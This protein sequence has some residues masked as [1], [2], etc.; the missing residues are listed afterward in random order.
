MSLTA[1]RVTTPGEF[2]ALAPAWADLAARSGR[3]S[4]F[5]SHDWFRSCWAA[6]PDRAEVLVVEDHGAPV[7]FL[8]LTSW[9]E[10]R[11]GLRVRC[12]GLLAT[13]DTPFADILAAAEIPAVLQ[14]G[15][16]HLGR[17][18]G[19]DTLRLW[20]L[21]VDSP[22]VKALETFLPGR[23]P[24]RRGGT[25]ASP[26]LAV[27]G[28][29]EAFWAGR[30]QR[31]RKTC[32]N[33]QNR[34]ERAGRVGVE[35]HRA[36]D[37]DGPLFAEVLD[38]T[39]RSWKADRR[40]AIANM[41]GMREFFGD[42]TRRASAR[43]WL[44]LWVLRVDGRAVAM[45]YQLRAAGRVHALR[46]DFDQ[47]WAAHSPGSALNVAIVRALFRDGGVRE[48]DMGPGLNDYKT[49][50]AT[51]QHETVSLHVYRPGAYGR[52]LAAVEGR[53]VPLG[54]RWMDAARRGLGRD[55]GMG[56]TG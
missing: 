40:L 52:L 39:A 3:T 25:L 47:A 49:R 5:L 26:Y 2:E 54:R 42:L 7:G 17:R 50:W 33:V 28:T 32:R 56:T 24:W 55:V 19:W 14:A 16:E 27:A 31:F 13:P 46:A 21:P 44:S 45:E 4:P 34:L 12:L 41:P 23:F 6:Q 35:E 18:P 38:L 20:K 30:S 37:P 11:H 10:R 29:W 9:V 43:G 51:G 1:R 8:P 22:T 48:Y 53:L 15:L 36:V